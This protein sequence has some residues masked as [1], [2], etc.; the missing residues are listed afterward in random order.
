MCVTG[1][2][3]ALRQEAWLGCYPSKITVEGF[4]SVFCGSDLDEQQQY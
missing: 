3:N 4:L 2:A 1:E